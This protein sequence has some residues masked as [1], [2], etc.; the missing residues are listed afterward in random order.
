MQVLHVLLGMCQALEI[1]E[2]GMVIDPRIFFFKGFVIIFPLAFFPSLL[3]CSSLFMYL[4]VENLLV[5]G[6]L[7]CVLARRPQG[8]PP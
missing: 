4:M 1:Q 3:F 5:L 8:S 2:K 6:C 7:Y